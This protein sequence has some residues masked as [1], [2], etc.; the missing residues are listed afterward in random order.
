[1]NGYKSY[2]KAATLCYL[3][4][5]RKAEGINSV[6]FS[7][8]DECYVPLALKSK[9]NQHGRDLSFYEFLEVLKLY[10]TRRED[11]PP[12]NDASARSFMRP[13]F[14]RLASTYCTEVL[15]M[16]VESCN[17]NIIPIPQSLHD[18]GKDSNSF[19]TKEETLYAFSICEEGYRSVNMINLPSFEGILSVTFYTSR[20]LYEFLESI[21]VGW[22]NLCDDIVVVLNNS[23]SI[24]YAHHT[25]VQ[26]YDIDAMSCSDEEKNQ[27]SLDLSLQDYDLV[28]YRVTLYVHVLLGDGLDT[29]F[30][31][32]IF[33]N[34]INEKL[35]QN[36]VLNN[37]E[38][39][40]NCIFKRFHQDTFTIVERTK[41]NTISSIGM[42]F[43]VVLLV[44]GAKFAYDKRVK[45]LVGAKFK[46]NVF[47]L[48]IPTTS[49]GESNE[50]DEE[51]ILIE[52]NMRSTTKNTPLMIKMANHHAFRLSIPQMPSDDERI[53]IEGE[54]YTDCSPQSYASGNQTENKI[55]DQYGVEKCNYEHMY[56]CESHDPP[57]S[58]ASS[59]IPAE[60]G[61]E[62]WK[63]HSSTSLIK[64]SF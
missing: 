56:L 8:E 33:F 30:W 42:S 31:S 4:F 16:P 43:F 26:N 47:P 40:D 63:F 1:M 52:E 13:T 51:E 21:E 53:L 38:N 27:L 45:K 24:S 6:A 64:G 35:K 20:T 14:V 41:K 49:T 55:S 61:I 23:G 3:A 57:I 10:H 5:Q 62:S 11:L 60:L 46:W 25:S 9:G 18:R 44:I 2:V 34:T 37:C 22:R 12:W 7:L 17:K 36:G 19:L 32:L 48:A 50:Y 28:C 58:I 54:R 15:K 29:E 39:A 59:V